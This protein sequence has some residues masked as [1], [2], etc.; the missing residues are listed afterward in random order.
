[1]GEYPHNNGSI[2]LILFCLKVDISCRNE[3]FF[4]SS[5]KQIIKQDL[6][7]ERF[8]LRQR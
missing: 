6:V 8:G 3:R 7:N 1:M 2:P 5:S 4:I